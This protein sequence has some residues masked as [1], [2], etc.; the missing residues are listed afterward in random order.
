MGGASLPS[1]ASAASLF[2]NPANT[3]ALPSTEAYF[4]Y[5][6]IY[7]GQ[8]GTGGI[9][10]GFAALAVPTKAGTFGVALGDFE[11]AGLMQERIVGLGWARRF[12]RRVEAGVA[13][14]FLYHRFLTG[15][16]PLAA[17]DPVFRDGSSRGAFAL[18]A[19]ARVAASDALALGLAVRN[20]N[21]PDVG[22]ASEDR[23]AREWQA[24]V[25]Y[26]VK[27][28][29]MRLTA[30]YLYRE[31]EGGTLAERGTPSVG[32][33]KSLAED[34]VKFRVGADPHQLSA[35]VGVGF[36][37]FGFDYAFVL[38]RELAGSNAGTHQVGLK[39]RFGGSKQ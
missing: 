14:K 35:G 37:G 38:A 25:S 34:R 2:V 8:E 10:Q 13:G 15:S 31:L 5:N 21:R 20:V 17:N 33:E 30:D 7:A 3:A 19:G 23:V 6:Q 27:G 9:G 32:L 22:L 26:D 28:W 36:G 12:T 24:G 39:Y 4:L 29:A 1:R 11:A 16:D 18:D